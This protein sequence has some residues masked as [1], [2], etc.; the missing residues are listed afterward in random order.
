MEIKYLQ[1]IYEHNRAVWKK[2]GSLFKE[3][4]N[5]ITVINT[6]YFMHHSENK[7]EY[8]GV[9]ELKCESRGLVQLVRNIRSDQET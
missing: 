2:S 1:N 3:M 6:D 9:L 5:V 4:H 7:V 8:T